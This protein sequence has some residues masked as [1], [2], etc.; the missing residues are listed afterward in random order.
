MTRPPFSRHL[1]AG[2]FVAA[3]VATL[4]ASTIDIIARAVGKKLGVV[5]G[6]TIVIDK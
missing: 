3:A 5:L 2:L 1:C 6:Q 4:L